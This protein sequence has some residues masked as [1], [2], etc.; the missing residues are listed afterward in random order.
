MNY[1]VIQSVLLTLKYKCVCVL[2]DN[3][4]DRESNHY[5]LSLSFT[6]KITAYSLP[7]CPG[8]VT[9]FWGLVPGSA[10]LWRRLVQWFW[11]KGHQSTFLRKGA[12][13]VWEAKGGRWPA[14]SWPRASPH[15]QVYLKVHHVRRRKKETCL[16][17][18]EE[19]L[20]FEHRWTIPVD[21]RHSLCTR[22][23]CY[24]VKGWWRRELH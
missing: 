19:S 23:R 14:L 10:L 4:E 11:T 20:H 15:N 21:K 18:Q 7:D 6:T 12:T 16:E 22:C 9:D 24:T 3:K 17:H 1:F 2:K 5:L 8:P 13:R